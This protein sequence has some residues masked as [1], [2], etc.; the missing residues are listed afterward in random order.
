MSR[1]FPTC[2][3]FALISFSTNAIAARHS[4]PTS[5]IPLALGINRNHLYYNRLEKELDNF[6]KDPPP[7]CSVEV[8]GSRKD[9]WIVTWTGLPGTIYA[10]EKYRLKILFPKEYPLKPPTV[11]FLQPAPVHAHVYSNGDI[12]LSSIGSDYLPTASVSSFVLSII[13]M[14]SNAKEKRLPID[15]HLQYLG[16]GYDAIDRAWRI[17]HKDDINIA[18]DLDTSYKGPILQLHWPSRNE[19]LRYNNSLSWTLPTNVYGWRAPSCR[20]NENESRHESSESH[21]K[22]LM[23]LFD[24]SLFKQ[25]KEDDGE[26]SEEEG[27]DT[28][29]SGDNSEDVPNKDS[30]DDAQ[31]IDDSAPTLNKDES[32]HG[33]A[34]A[35][36]E[37][38]TRGLDDA[39]S[40]DVHDNENTKADVDK[41]DTGPSL[42]EKRNRKKDKHDDEDNEKQN[43]DDIYDIDDALSALGVEYDTSDNSLL[44]DITGDEISPN[45]TTVDSD[46]DDDKNKLRRNIK[47]DY[48]Q[49]QNTTT[50][51]SPGDDTLKKSKG[52]RKKHKK[53]QEATTAS[54]A[55]FDLDDILSDSSTENNDDSSLLDDVDEKSSDDSSVLDGLDDN[56]LLDDVDEKSS[57]DSDNNSLLDDSDDISSDET[58]DSSVLDDSDEKSSD[59]SDEK[60]SDDSDEKSS[61]DSDN[62]SLLDDSDDIS[63]DETDDNSLLDD[64]DEKSSDDSDNNS[65]LDDSDDKSSDDTSEEEPSEPPSTTAKLAATISLSTA[66]NSQTSNNQSVKGAT[67]T[68]FVAGTNLDKHSLLSR[69]FSLALKHLVRALNREKQCVLGLYGKPKCEVTLSLWIHFFRNYGTHVITRIVLGGKVSY[70]RKEKTESTSKDRNVKATATA[71]VTKVNAEAKADYKDG[72]KESSKSTQGSN[73]FDM[74]GGNLMPKQEQGNIDAGWTNSIV[75]SPMPISIELTPLALLFEHSGYKEHYYEALLHYAKS[76]IDKSSTK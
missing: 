35:A 39:T 52:K 20:F 73:A 62:N 10:G 31:H 43:I 46:E 17:L 61:D 32:D 47:P 33:K 74:L 75:E 5:N 58:D 51:V 66:F 50:D 48:P 60:S 29:G 14:L 25:D 21:S 4:R 26:N 1:L 49:S 57:D 34:K 27:G 42:L 70:E 30:G 65:L 53:K 63:S 76:G 56:S 3:L 37:K 40:T 2:V 41:H 7:N 19:S 44:D 72:E 36:E 12:C 13:S 6:R 18:I 16:L 71:E 67:C 8:F 64:V 22:E 45:D 9:I 54:S 11:Y 28:E 59:D 38:S 68:S 55:S 15:N 23:A 24:A 69:S